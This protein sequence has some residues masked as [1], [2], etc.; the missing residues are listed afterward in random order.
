MADAEAAGAHWVSDDVMALRSGR[1]VRILDRGNCINVTAGEGNPIEIMDLSFGVQVAAIRHL[2]N[3]RDLPP[4]VHSLP[5]EADDAVARAALTTATPG[6]P[7]PP[8][9]RHAPEPVQVYS[10]GL[11]IP[12]TAPSVLGGAVAVR[13]RRILHVGER[14]WVVR[15]LREDGIRFTEVHW[16]GVILP[17]LVNAHTHLQYTSMAVLGH[18]QYHG[19]DDWAQAFNQIYDAQALDWA[20]S[21]RQGAQLSLRYGVT[22]VADVVTDPS[23]ASMRA[24]TGWRTGRSWTGPTRIGP[25]TGRTR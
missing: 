24:C 12:I 13:G 16:P 4:G 2:L 22:T 18:G 9:P 8:L 21:A 10:A 3:H 7:H 23:A 20:S 17:G 6:S 25:A 19:F 14:D 5:R 11:V 1:A 15:A